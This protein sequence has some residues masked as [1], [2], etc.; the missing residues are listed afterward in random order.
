MNEKHGALLYQI[1]L[2]IGV[3]VV[4]F[5]VG[6]FTPPFANKSDA[7]SS[8]SNIVDED[9]LT[10]STRM[11][12]P[13]TTTTIPSTRITTFTLS[14]T[15]SSKKSA[16]SSTG[17]SSSSAVATTLAAT[18]TD[19]DFPLNLNTATKE[20]LM[21]INGIGE[22]LA[23]RIIAYREEHGGFTSLEELTNVKGIAEGRYAKF[24]PYLTLS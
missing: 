8:V 14:T 16:S 10:E 13:V 3:A 11:D 5:S 23:E 17:N 20:E 21:T 18:V 1:L 19:V 24:A 6:R 4:F 22:V 15:S 2:G 7:T 9:P 12:I